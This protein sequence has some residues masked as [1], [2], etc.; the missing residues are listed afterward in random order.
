MC[1]WDYG[2]WMSGSGGWMI[3]G[4]FWMA[5][6]WLVPILLLFALAKYLF[7]SQKSGA[8][9]REETRRSALDILDEVYARG[10]LTREDYLQKRD[11][12]QKT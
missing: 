12:L 6:I 5:L 11:D 2:G 7:G 3:F 9:A 10:E 8:P 4:W 1:G